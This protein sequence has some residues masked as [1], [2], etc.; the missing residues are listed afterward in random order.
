ML[1]LFNGKIDMLNNSFICNN[2]FAYFE[3]IKHHETTVAMLNQHLGRLSGELEKK[4]DY[5]ANLQHEM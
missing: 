1:Y 4:R 5:N 2:I 3:D